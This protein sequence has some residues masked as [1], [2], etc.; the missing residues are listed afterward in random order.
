M[1]LDS[2]WLSFIFY[3]IV[4]WIYESTVRSMITEGHFINRG[5]L[6]GPYC[7]VYGIGAVSCYFLLN[8]IEN[9]LTL[10]LAAMFLCSVI[11]YMTS[12]GME[13][14]FHARWWDYSRFPFQLH[15]RIC[16][17]GALVFGFANVLICF[18]VQPD[19]LNFLKMINPACTYVFVILSAFVFMADTITTLIAWTNLN[20]R[21]DTLHKELFEKSNNSMEELSNYLL[22]KTPYRISHGKWGIQICMNNLNVKLKKSELRFLHAFPNVKLLRYEKMLKT[23]RIKEFIKNVFDKL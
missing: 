21:L 3:S 12:Y 17:Y 16:L 8:R 10:F 23:I 2:A 14:L 13:K 5:F 7:P 18:I 6:L 1:S 20:Q 19:F 9:P 15:G 4:G 11:E 22:Q